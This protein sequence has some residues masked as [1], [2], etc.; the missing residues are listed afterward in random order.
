M[1]S[2]LNAE[3]LAGRIESP[4]PVP[5]ASPV[6]GTQVLLPPQDRLALL[7]LL[8]GDFDAAWRRV[9]AAGQ[10]IRSGGEPIDDATGLRRAAESRAQAM[11]HAMISQL[12]R[13]GVLA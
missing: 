2:A 7:A 3:V 13:L 11:G 4:G 6:A 1:A 12:S 5:F 8:E 9:Q 10:V